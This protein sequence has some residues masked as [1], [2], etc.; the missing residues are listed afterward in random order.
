MCNKKTQQAIKC[1]Q[2]HSSSRDVFKISSPLMCTWVTT[3]RTTR[4]FGARLVYKLKEKK[5]YTAFSAYVIIIS[6]YIQ[7]VRIKITIFLHLPKKVNLIKLHRPSASVETHREIYYFFMALEHR[8]FTS[9]HLNV[10]CALPRGKKLSQ[11]YYFQLIYR[12]AGEN[13]NVNMQTT[14]TSSKFDTDL[15]DCY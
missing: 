4:S 2:T 8:V 10:N 13:I 15:L 5:K 7:I 12:D 9:A 3:F 1:R 6:K 11:K 14:E